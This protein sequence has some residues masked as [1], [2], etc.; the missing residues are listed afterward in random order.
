M[1]H[2]T[3]LIARY[4]ETDKMG[5]IH[6]SVYAVWF[7]AARTEFIKKMGISYSGCEERGLMLPLIGLECKFMK[8]AYY[9]DVIAIES[10]IQK[11][12]PV[13]LVIVYTARNKKTDEILATGKTVHV[14]TDGE[15]KPVDM[16]KKAPDIFQM[17]I[18]NI[19]E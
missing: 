2:I 15:R 19:T 4:A 5:I 14:W 16:R 9:E 6:H 17:M 13:R 8:P 10:S 12:T 3:E 18:N 7:E 1:T 11:A